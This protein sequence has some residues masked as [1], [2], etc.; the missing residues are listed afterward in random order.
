MRVA[1]YL[2]V[3]TGDQVR[4]GL[5]M[6]A[7]R[8]GLVLAAE[9]AGWDLIA[10]FVDEGISGRVPWI[11]R[12]GLAAA[13][14]LVG[15]GGAD[16]VAIARLDRLA[17]RVEDALQL[18]RQLGAGLICL[19][20]SIDTT[21]ATG[22][23]GLTVL[24]AAAELE[25]TLASERTRAAMMAKA[26][27]GERIGRPRSCPDEVLDEVLE[28]RAAGGTL[29]AIAAAMNAAAVPTPAGSPRWWPSHVSRLLRTQD[30]RTVGRVQ[31]WPAGSSTRSSASPSGKA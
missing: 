4:S 23:F 17:R 22:W 3:S 6:E 28:L 5:G 1:T 7:Q 24:A 2:R 8:A 16:A 9:R 27:R 29:V 21:S 15:T 13:V 12:P 19:N 31:G 26:A 14:R 10:E 30:A 11:E 18:V 20:P 25:S